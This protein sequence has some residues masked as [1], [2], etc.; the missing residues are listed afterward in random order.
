MAL[1]TYA[2]LKSAIADYLARSDLTSQIV[3]Y[4]TL[5]EAAACRRLKVRPMETSTTLTPSS[6]TASLPSGYL[7]WRRVTW[8]GS[9]KR[10]L[11]Y[12]HPSM[13]RLTYPDEASGTPN[14]FTIEG[15][16]LKVRP[17][18]DTTLD[19]DYFAKTAAVSGSLNWLFT[20]HPDAYLFGSLAEAYAMLKDWETAAKWGARTD[21]VFQEIK[22]LNFNEQGSLAIRVAGATP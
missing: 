5:F 7:G 14:D 4:I 12:V 15:S 16:S 17:I 22:D 2:E 10:E 1:S 18:S 20:N 13:L 19:F 6:G 21:G 3:D 8:N 9:P 11:S